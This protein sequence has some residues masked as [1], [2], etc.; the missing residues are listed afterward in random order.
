MTTQTATNAARRASLLAELDRV[1][2]SPDGV[3]TMLDGITAA[4]V[5]AMIAG[6][7]AVP[8]DLLT[9]LADLEPVA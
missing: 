3:Q 1:G 2:L 7:R 9:A 5:R 8:V 6:R 4:H